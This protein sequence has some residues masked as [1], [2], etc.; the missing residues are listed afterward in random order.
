MKAKKELNYEALKAAT[1][2]AV[3][4]HFVPEVNVIKQRIHGLV[5]QDYLKRDE[6][7]MNNFIY[8]A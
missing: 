3:K 6:D 7:D 2:E 4:N 1:I 5:D 8:V